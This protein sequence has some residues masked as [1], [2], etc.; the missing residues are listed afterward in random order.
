MQKKLSRSLRSI[1]L[2]ALFIAPGIALGAEYESGSDACKHDLNGFKIATNQK[3][4][5]R[6]LAMSKDGKHCALCFVDQTKHIMPAWCLAQEK[7]GADVSQAAVI[8]CTDRAAKDN[9]LDPK[10]KIVECEGC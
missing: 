9:D 2:L 5:P 1:S 4:S 3:F 8:V 6:A 10:C 7:K